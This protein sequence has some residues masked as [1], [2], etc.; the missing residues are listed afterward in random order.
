MNHMEK[1][2]LAQE[3][4]RSDKVAALCSQG[5][6]SHLLHSWAVFSHTVLIIQQDKL[7]SEVGLGYTEDKSKG[8]TFS[9]AH[10]PSYFYVSLRL[11]HRAVTT[12]QFQNQ[13]DS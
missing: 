11:I 6:R 3:M 10:L 8:N 2:C 7:I 5:A 1:G 12:I 4:P 13:Q 9:Q